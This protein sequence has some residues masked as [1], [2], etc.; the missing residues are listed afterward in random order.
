LGVYRVKETTKE[1]FVTNAVQVEMQ[2]HHLYIARHVA[3]IY[4]AKHGIVH[5]DMV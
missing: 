2:R 3:T 1:E 4:R 5:N